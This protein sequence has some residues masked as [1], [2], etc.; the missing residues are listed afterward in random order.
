MDSKL[1]RGM[2]AGALTLAL[3]L[4]LPSTAQA[5]Q[6]SGVEIWEATCGRCHALQPTN[7]YYPKDWRSVGTHMTITARLTSAQGEAVLAFLISGARTDATAALPTSAAP[8][9][10]PASMSAELSEDQIARL[11]AYVSGLERASR[12]VVA[13]K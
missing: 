5:Q 3:S 1:I 2:A 4:L 11:E 6:R 12:F 10:V 9:S 8:S 13:S 7:K